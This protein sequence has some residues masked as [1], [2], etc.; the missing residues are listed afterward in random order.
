VDLL[1][2]VQAREQFAAF[3]ARR[4]AEMDLAEGALL[5]AREEYPHLDAAACRLRLRGLAEECRRSVGPGAPGPEV[6]STLNEIL[7]QEAGF[8]GDRESY[9]DPRNL[10]LNEVLE[11]RLG[12]PITL[13][14]V[15]LE[16]GRMLGLP[17]EGI[18][19][20]GHFLVAC[21]DSEHEIFIDP[22]EAGRQLTLAECEALLKLRLGSEA[23]LDRR[24]LQPVGARAILHRLLNNLKSIYMKT[25]EAGRALACVERMLMLMPDSLVDRRDRGLL[26]LHL[27][28]PELG[29]R[30]LES[31][32]A[33]A[34]KGRP[35]S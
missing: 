31:V 33:A 5:A 13:S 12:I 27:D 18:N 32:Q 16:V 21:R 8:R 34:L 24:L 6:L 15:Y 35:A 3:A 10:Y 30:D 25:A 22:F 23:V 2:R 9:Y 1:A 29:R 26:L 17:L 14:I 11:R 28:F 7:F 4:E 19:F 20:P